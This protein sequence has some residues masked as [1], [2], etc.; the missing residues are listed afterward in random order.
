MWIACVYLCACMRLDYIYVSGQDFALHKYFYNN[1]G[2]AV[3]I[4]DNIVREKTSIIYMYAPTS[5]F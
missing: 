1:T 5:D 3:E 2:R 4:W